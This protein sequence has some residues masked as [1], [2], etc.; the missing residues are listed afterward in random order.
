MSNTTRAIVIGGCVI[1][2]FYL[3]IQFGVGLDD[4]ER[5][6]ADPADSVEL[7]E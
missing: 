2:L 7:E 3:A 5:M 1:V 4:D 6:Q